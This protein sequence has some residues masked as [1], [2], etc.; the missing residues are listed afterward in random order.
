MGRVMEERREW[1]VTLTGMYL[2]W[3]RRKGYEFSVY[4]PAEDYRRWIEKNNLSIKTFIPD[5]RE[6]PPW[7]EVKVTEFNELQRRLSSLELSELALSVSGLNVYGF[8]KGETGIHKLLLRGEEKDAVTPFHTVVVKVME[9]LDPVNSLWYLKSNCQTGVER[10][11][12][13]EPGRKKQEAEES[14]EVIRLYSPEGERFV[15]DLRTEVKTTQVT[16]VLEGD[17]DDF[18]LAWLRTE[19]V[20]EAWKA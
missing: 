16:Q 6:S 13:H 5:Y 2:R 15:R 19:E 10:K 8:L 1:L 20:A 17:L 3:M 18:V 4:V 9:L 14:Y 7:A 11:K 12:M